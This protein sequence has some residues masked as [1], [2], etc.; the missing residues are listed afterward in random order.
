MR[1]SHRKCISNVQNTIHASYD[2]FKKARPWEKQHEIDWQVHS[3]WCR[4]NHWKLRETLSQVRCVL[5]NMRFAVPSSWFEI[6]FVVSPGGRQPAKNQG[7]HSCWTSCTWRGWLGWSSDRMILGQFDVDR[8]PVSLRT[9]EMWILQQTFGNLKLFFSNICG[10]IGAFL[11]VYLQMLVS[12]WKAPVSRCSFSVSRCLL[13]DIQRYCRV[14][15]SLQ[16]CHC[17]CFWVPWMQFASCHFWWNSF[18]CRAPM[19]QV[20]CWLRS[21]FL[22]PEFLRRLGSVLSH[23]TLSRENQ[24]AKNMISHTLFFANAATQQQLSRCKKYRCT[25]GYCVRPVFVIIRIMI[26]R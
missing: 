6:A 24:A 9:S 17:R 8:L 15:A 10:C 12:N 23:C 26:G 5:W 3:V 22:F 7:F 11:V 13:V 21:L 18:L 1:L 4:L 20:S 25:R 14:L 2:M 19:C 16:S